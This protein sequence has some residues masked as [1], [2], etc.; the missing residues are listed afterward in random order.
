MNC[1]ANGTEWWS[2]EGVSL[3][4][5]Q[6]NFDRDNSGPC[7]VCDGLGYLEKNDDEV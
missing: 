2:E 6:A 7:H 5:S 3:H 4:P 1:D